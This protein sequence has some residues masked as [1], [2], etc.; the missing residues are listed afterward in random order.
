MSVFCFLFAHQLAKHISA[1]LRP[2]EDVELVPS[3]WYQWVSNDAHHP[4][5]ILRGL[6][7]IHRPVDGSSGGE[8]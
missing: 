3:S 6:G 7:E 1:S 2:L 5:S 4:N 8:G